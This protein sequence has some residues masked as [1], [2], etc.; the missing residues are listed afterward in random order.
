MDQMSLSAMLAIIKEMGIPGVLF[1]VWYLSDRRYQS[2][3][4]ALKER[5]E[6]NMTEV[7]QMYINN[8]ELVKQYGG[9][10]ENL[11]EIVVLN[12]QTMQRV[13]EAVAGN[14]Y[15]PLNRINKDAKGP[16]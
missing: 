11:Q 15:C 12:T 8:V 1:L 13:W 3:M 4:A 10:A 14:Q 5:Y 9:L 16:Q 7:R 2:D 6:A